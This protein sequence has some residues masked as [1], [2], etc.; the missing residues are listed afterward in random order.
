MGEGL[1]RKQLEQFDDQLNESIEERIG[2]ELL[3]RIPPVS[4][5]NVDVLA[6]TANVRKGALLFARVDRETESVQFLSG[7][8]VWGSV[9]F[10]TAMQLGERLES[11]I[12]KVLSCQDGVLRLQVVKVD[13][14]QVRPS[15]DEE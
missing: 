6:A 4:H 1:R 12:F 2:E 11:M 7:H 10:E 15:L 13:R 14:R 9:G 5:T 3:D 8:E